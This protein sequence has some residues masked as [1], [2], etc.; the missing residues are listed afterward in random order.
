MDESDL[1]HTITREALE[2]CN[3]YVNLADMNINYR[4]DLNGSILEQIT[5]FIIIEK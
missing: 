3:A 1:E 2:L 5:S 4:I